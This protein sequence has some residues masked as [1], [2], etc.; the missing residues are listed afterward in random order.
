MMNSSE[1]AKAASFA[2]TMLEPGM[3]KRNCP[4]SVGRRLKSF[5]RPISLRPNKAPRMPYLHHNS[6]SEL[7]V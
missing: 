3:P 6:Q 1:W 5:V 2:S 4:M 7:L